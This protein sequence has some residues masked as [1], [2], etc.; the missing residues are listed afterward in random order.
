MS[1][2]AN[3]E[4]ENIYTSEEKSTDNFNDI[5]SPTSSNENN[6]I[7]FQLPKL[8]CDVNVKK[9]NIYDRFSYVQFIEFIIR[10][11]ILKSKKSRGCILSWLK[12]HLDLEI[13][14]CNNFIIE[15]EKTL[16]KFKNKRQLLMF[17]ERK[18]TNIHNINNYKDI[19][20]YKQIL[21]SYNQKKTISYYVII[22]YF[23][24]LLYYILYI[25]FFTM[26][27]L[28]ILLTIFFQTY[29][30]EDYLCKYSSSNYS[31]LLKTI[32]ST[33]ITLMNELN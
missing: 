28:L 22:N 29:L 15:N 12:D 23:C 17:L 18:F 16:F 24:C 10:S 3:E 2:S 20:N 11:R 33:A 31:I 27:I 6:D 14:S 9:F 25:A 5:I 13:P 30:F 1:N 21:S 32:K 19:T 7:S 26:L 8:Y 4:W